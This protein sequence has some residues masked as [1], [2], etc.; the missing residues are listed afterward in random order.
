[1]EMGFHFHSSLSFPLCSVKIP[2]GAT[3]HPA[4]FL[5]TI[6]LAQRA[7]KEVVEGRIGFKQVRVNFG[8]DPS[9]NAFGQ[10][11]SEGRF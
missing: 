8:D 3:F 1:M 7:R 2:K 4:G 6:G 10:L 5:E 11:L 9:G